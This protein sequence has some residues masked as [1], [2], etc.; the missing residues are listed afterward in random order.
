MRVRHDHHIHT[1][2]SNHASADMAVPTIVAQ[3]TK[4][5]LGRIVI[6]EHVPEMPRYRRAV[7]E[8]KVASVP[9]PQ[10]EA[11]RQEVDRW[12]GR[13][14]LRILVGAEIDANPHVRDGRLLVE[15]VEGIDVVVAST[16]FLPTGEALWYDVKELFD[17]ERLAE[18]YR[19]WMVW[20]MHIAANP[21]VD[22]LA[23]PGVEMAAIGAIERFEGCLL[24]TSP[25]PRDS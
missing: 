13:Q 2:F 10:I 17:P 5:G 25:S 14:A 15:S 7:L 3:A 23:H 16:H 6:L 24:Y 1:V 11:I 19:E 20:I 18:I 9:M 12:R 21:H 22:V 4:L 8:E